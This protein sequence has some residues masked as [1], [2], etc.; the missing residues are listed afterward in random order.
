MHIQILCDHFTKKINIYG[1][2]LT[3][4]STM[5]TILTGWFYSTLFPDF[6]KKIVNKRTTAYYYGGTKLKH[7]ENLQGVPQL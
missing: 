6:G 5:G 7:S 4:A 3:G 1:M 2:V